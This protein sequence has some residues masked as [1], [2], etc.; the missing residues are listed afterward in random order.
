MTASM[1]GTV[2]YTVGAATVTVGGDPERDT[3]SVPGVAS[4]AGQR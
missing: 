2:L 1:A 3:D 4:L